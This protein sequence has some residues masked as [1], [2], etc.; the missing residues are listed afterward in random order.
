MNANS[1]QGER[2]HKHAALIKMGARRSLIWNVNK[3]FIILTS[4]IAHKAY[5]IHPPGQTM[6]YCDDQHTKETHITAVIKRLPACKST[7][8]KLPSHLKQSNDI[9]STSW[10]AE[11]C[12]I[13][14]E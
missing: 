13:Y 1:Q 9:L 12:H 5:V 10:T 11:I 7:I 8:L 6:V 2:V 4:T 3:H 14:L